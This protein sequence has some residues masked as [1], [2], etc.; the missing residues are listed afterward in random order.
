MLGLLIPVPPCFTHNDPFE[1]TESIRIFSK[2]LT[3]LRVSPTTIR[4]RILK[5]AISR[6]RASS[7]GRFTHNDPFEDTESRQPGHGHRRQQSFTHNDPFEDTESSASS[8]LCCAAR[9]V[10]HPQRSVR[11]Y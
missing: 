5:A 8:A 9:A 7:E 3:N 11:G 4:S 10:F 1:D 2:R 6:T